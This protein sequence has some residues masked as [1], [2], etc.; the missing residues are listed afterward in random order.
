MFGARIVVADAD[1]GFRQKIRETLVHAGYL[2]TGEVGDGRS[3][4]KVIFQTEPD[5]VI[6]DSR[7]PGSEGLEI[8]RIIEEYRFSAVILIT[9]SHD[10]ELLEEAKASWV[11]AYLVKPV[12]DSQLLP[13][14]EIALSNFKKLVKLE[15]ENKR[16]KQ[17]LEERKLIEKAKGLVMEVKG[18]SEKEAYKYM[19]KLS[20][21]KCKSLA[22]VA[23]HIITQFDGK[24]T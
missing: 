1:A 20:M 17:A 5:L 21:D 15:Q 24:A 3:A 12:S 8:V 10:L 13:A 7:L 22:S 14:V 16:L 23:R 9:S 19:Q 11:F 2:V 4:L 18:I 6:I